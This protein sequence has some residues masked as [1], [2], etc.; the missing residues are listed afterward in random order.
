MKNKN[1][2]ADSCDT[3]TYGKYVDLMNDVAF[4][5]V[6]GQED[7]KDLL[8]ALLNEL[9]PELHIEKLEFCKNR[10]LSF[11]K[12]LKSSV[13]DVSCK[14]EAGTQIDVEVQVRAQDWFADR[15]LYYS[16]YCIQNQIRRGQDEYT[17]NPVYIV[18]I[19]A[20]TRRHAPEWDGSILSGYSLR[21]DRTHELMTDNLH[22]VFVELEHFNKKWED[23]DNDKERFYFCIR[24]LHEL[25]NLPDG[26][27]EGI[28]AKLARQSE[29][30][31]MPSDVKMKYIKAMTTDIDRR[32]QMKYAQRVARETG[33]AEGRAE[34]RAKGLEEGRAKGLEE[35]RA[36]G[37]AE[38]EAIGALNKA[39]ETA[40]NMK[41]EGIPASVIVR[42]T[43]VTLEQVA[44]L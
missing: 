19:D 10:Q 39:M 43:G 33:L 1:I 37:R 2:Q 21:E 20:F 32:A 28:W 13:F 40:R 15:C 8:I 41:A 25:D 35:G 27:A 23:I 26:F 38:G 31:E 36:E 6:F 11:A 24:H 5:W 16:T 42:C 29:L 12:D 22:F 18:S 4:Q 14:L 44:E 3:L 9:I 30:A 34:G 7:N 17:L